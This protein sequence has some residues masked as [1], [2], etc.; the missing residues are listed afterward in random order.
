KGIFSEQQFS[1]G[2]HKSK[3]AFR[4]RQVELVPS[5]DASATMEFHTLSPVVI[6]C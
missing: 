3:V 4:V 5:P 1:L 6:T 2:D